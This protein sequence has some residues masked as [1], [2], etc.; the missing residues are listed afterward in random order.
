MGIRC[1]PEGC[2]RC[3]VDMTRDEE[4]TVAKTRRYRVDRPGF[5]QRG[6]WV[7][8]P[9]NRTTSW[10]AGTRDMSAQLSVPKEGRDVLRQMWF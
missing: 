1:T 6:S 9:L 5:P 4:V 7:P 8:T 3:R 10:F 2:R